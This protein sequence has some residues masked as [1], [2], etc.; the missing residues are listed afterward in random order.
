MDDVESLAELHGRLYQDEGW[1]GNDLWVRDGWL[2]LLAQLNRSLR[3]IDA[4]F[5]VVQAKEKFGRLRVYLLPST[6]GAEVD[7][8]LEAAVDA[9]EAASVTICDVCA[10]PGLLL[11]DT[12]PHRTRCV[13]HRDWHPPTAQGR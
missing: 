3:V 11:Y 1:A 9:A 6:N 5:V 7:Q 12:G 2:P 10:A 8:E 13:E 4:G